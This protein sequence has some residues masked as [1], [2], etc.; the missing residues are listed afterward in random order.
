MFLYHPGLGEEGA[1][2]GKGDEVKGK[3]GSWLPLPQ[4][5]TLGG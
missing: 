2:P 1:A 4:A 3:A 5:I